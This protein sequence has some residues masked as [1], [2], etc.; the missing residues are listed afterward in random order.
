MVCGGRLAKCGYEQR[1][2]QAMINSAGAWK[3]QGFAD[4]YIVHVY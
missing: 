3:A 1:M 4:G 2:E